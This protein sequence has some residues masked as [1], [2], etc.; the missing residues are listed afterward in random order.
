M[1]EFKLDDLIWMHR[2]TAEEVRKAT[3]I[4]SATLSNMRTGKNKNVSINTLDL[5]CK[6]FNCKVSDILEFIND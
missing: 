2:T 3:G 1:I 5:L 4:S 6:H